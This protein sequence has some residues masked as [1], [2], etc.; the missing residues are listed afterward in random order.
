MDNEVLAFC[1]D[2]SKAFDRVP[3][4]EL[5]KNVSNIGVGVRILE[6]LFDYLPEKKEYTMV[7]NFKRDELEVTTGVK[8]G[9]LLGPLLSC[10]FINDLPDV[11]KLSEKIQF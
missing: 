6:G 7:E 11:L 9:S 2:F 10:I 5:L 3:H 8:Q 4:F 1:T